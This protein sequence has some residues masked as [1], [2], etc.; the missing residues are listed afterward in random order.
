[1]N[2]Q[3]DMMTAAQTLA[4]ADVSM[5]AEE[6]PSE[7]LQELMTRL[8]KAYVV[9]REAGESFHPVGPGITATEAAVTVSGIVAAAD[10]QM[11]ELTLWNS[12]GRLD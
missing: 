9:K 6:M 10:M 7:L 12:W 5:L 2:A 4:V 8:T 1:M 11:F 3:T